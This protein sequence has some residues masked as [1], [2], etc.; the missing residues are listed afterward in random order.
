LAQQVAKDIIGV[1]TVV[2]PKTDPVVGILYEGKDDGEVIHEK[3]AGRMISGL[4]INLEQRNRM[5]LY[6]RMVAGALNAHE[7]GLPGSGSVGQ[8][9][10]VRKI[11][12]SLANCPKYLNCKRIYPSLPEPR[13]ISDSPHLSPE[14]LDLLGKADMFFI[15]SSDHDK[16]MDMN[17][18][19]GPPGFVRVESNA[20]HGAVL[21]YPEKLHIWVKWTPNLALSGAAFCSPRTHARHG[22][23]SVQGSPF[24][25]LMPS[26]LPLS[27]LTSVSKSSE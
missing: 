19:G 27:L 24:W 8:V 14:A 20:E 6:G 23:N 21:V 3:G 13:L 18:R 22:S 4:S 7:E 25:I 11:E 5:K 15:S 26:S 17:H 10:L 9:Q 1:R 16:D 2:D 12:Q